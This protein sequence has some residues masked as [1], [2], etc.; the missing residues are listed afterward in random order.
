MCWGLHIMDGDKL[1]R[2]IDTTGAAI[3]FF[4]AD[5]VCYDTRDDE[6]SDDPRANK[7]PEDDVA[8]GDFCLCP[9]DIDYLLEKTGY[10]RIEHTDPRWDSLDTRIER[11]L[12]SNAGGKP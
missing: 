5:N 8:N 12:N 9:I 11:A 3:Q 7:S 6:P 4:G 1:V 10:V 2:M